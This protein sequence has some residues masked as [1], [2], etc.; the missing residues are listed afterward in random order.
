[1]DS[2]NYVYQKYGVWLMDGVTMK[3]PIIDMA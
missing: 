1:M 2:I 3:I